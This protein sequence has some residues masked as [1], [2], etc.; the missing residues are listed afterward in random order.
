MTNSINK[1]APPLLTPP[2]SSEGASPMG[3]SGF[4]PEQGNSLH[5]IG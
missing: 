2:P 3:N 4:V 5:Q 1:G